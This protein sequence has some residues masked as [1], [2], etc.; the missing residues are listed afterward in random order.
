MIISVPASLLHVQATV[1]PF[2]TMTV[3]LLP[4]RLLTSEPQC[5][6]LPAKG[7][8]PGARPLPV[9]G[10]VSREAEPCELW[11][12]IHHGMGL[13]PLAGAGQVRSGGQLEGQRKGLPGPGAT[14]LCAQPGQRAGQRA[15]RSMPGHAASACL[16]SKYRDLQRVKVT[17]SRPSPNL[18]YGNHTGR[19][20]GKRILASPPYLTLPSSS[21]AGF[22]PPSA[23]PRP[24]SPSRP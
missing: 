24:A 18:T 6:V 22:S 12:W 8:H 16:P 14:P 4:L 11:R 1:S 13:A 5:Q 17:A 19:H 9:A 3:S 20:P 2:L 15:G 23:S 21:Q 10:R 7:L